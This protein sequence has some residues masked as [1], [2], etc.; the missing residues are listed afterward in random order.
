MGSATAWSPRVAPSAISG[1]YLIMKYK[2][3]RKIWIRWSDKAGDFI[4]EAPAA[5]KEIALT[6]AEAVLGSQR[7]RDAL[8][9]GQ[10]DITTLSITVCEMRD[11]PRPAE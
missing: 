10:Y 4:V 9:S 3:F 1:R 6:L 7:V 2:P 5:D 11:G 8:T